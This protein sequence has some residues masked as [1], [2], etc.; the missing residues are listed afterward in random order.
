LLG[1]ADGAVVSPPEVGVV[2][3][4]RVGV[5]PAGAVGVVPA[6]SQWARWKVRRLLY[7]WPLQHFTYTTCIRVY[8]VLL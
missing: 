7:S 2:P 3:S 4:V 6:A 5:V 1:G 8:T